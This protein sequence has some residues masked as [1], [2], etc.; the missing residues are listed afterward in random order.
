[1]VYRTWGKLELKQPGR[2]RPFARDLAPRSSA[3]R[4]LFRSVAAWFRA[5]PS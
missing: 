1:M 4:E 2:L 5:Q 3:Q